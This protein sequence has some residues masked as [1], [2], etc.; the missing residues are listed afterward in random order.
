MYSNK[1]IRRAIRK[2]VKRNGVQN[3]R[4]VIRIFAN[5]YQTSKQRISGNL[6]SLK[7]DDKTIN[8][9][10]FIPATYSIMQ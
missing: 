3:T 1:E 10:T 6:R 9:T 8:I 5:A 2:Y 4:D 7:Y